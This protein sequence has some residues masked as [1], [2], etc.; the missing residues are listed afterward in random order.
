MNNSPSKRLIAQV[1]QR[2]S[3]RTIATRFFIDFCVI[4]GIFAVVVLTCN[5][6]GLIPENFFKENLE[7]VAIVPVLSFALTLVFHQRTDSRDA[8]RLIDQRM[9]KKDLYL[10]LSTLDTA[11]G[12]YQ[13]MVVSQANDQANAIRP[14]TVV[15]FHPWPKLAKSCIILLSLVLL[16]RYT[17]SYDMFG[18]QAEAEK[19]KQ[20]LKEVKKIKAETIKKTNQLKQKR[21]KQK[22]SEKINNFS[23]Q[24]KKAFSMLKRKHK[25]QNRKNLH[26]KL[27][28]AQNMQKKMKDEF[29]KRKRM[30]RN[31]RRFGEG[32]D[33]LSKKWQKSLESGKVPESLKK[34]IADIKK[35]AEQAKNETDPEKKKAIMQQL[36]KAMSKINKLA[37]AQV[38]SP[39][40]SQSIKEAMQNLSMPEGQE[41]SQEAMEQLV[42]SMELAQEQLE[43]IAQSA[44]DMEDLEKMMKTLKDAMQANQKK[45]DGLD[46]SDCE[47]CMSMEDYEALFKKLCE[48]Q[49]EGGGQGGE[50]QGKGNDAE[51]NKDLK[52][53]SKYQRTRTQLT[54]G[55]ILST[56][57]TKA[58]ARSGEA[59]K[60]Y[61]SDSTRITQKIDEVMAI[62][63]IPAGYAPLLKGYFKDKA[64]DEKDTDST[65]TE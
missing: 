60:N 20:L 44:R 27:K 10:T 16:A 24:T 43:Q 21:P 65:K 57:S 17:P 36:S 64:I 40:L 28:S 50:G 53:A 25:D 4:A 31:N 59:Q 6:L 42:K 9:D 8:A 63:R 33:A 58:V 29:N 35:L 45:K 48:G 3:K 55:K 1:R 11:P 37:N 30:A 23:D 49:G 34:T 15:I 52:M 51:E 5:L 46:K 19:E 38:G 14:E 12:E 62:E 54:R 32:Q 22:N 7:L 56:K 41:L 2:L 13:D 47:S 39:E 26:N 61:I 18:N